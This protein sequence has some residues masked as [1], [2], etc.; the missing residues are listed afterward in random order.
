[1]IYFFL[2]ILLIFSIIGCLAA[3]SVLIGLIQTRGVPFISSPKKKYNLILQSA[4]LKPGEVLCD[5]GCGKAHLL[6]K[7]AKEYGVKG[8]GYELS[9]WPY[10]WAKF[11]VWL[12]EAEVKIY[13]QNFLEA[14]LS[15]ADVIY[16]YLFPHIM[17]KLSH[18]FITE[19]KPGARVISYAFSL[20]YKQPDQEIV[21]NPNCQ[22]SQLVRI[23]LF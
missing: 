3:L 6:I 11:N 18:K 10:L 2:I 15:S 8:I 23:Y 22:D 17:E 21:T 5:L 14:D 16:C 20:P 19:L 13:R 4:K 7:A 12:S 1:M 9:W